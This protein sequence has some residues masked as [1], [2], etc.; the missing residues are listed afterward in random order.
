[1]SQGLC[2]SCGAVANLP[3]EHNQINCTYCGSVVTRQEAEA[4]AEEQKGL[5]CIGSVIL[6]QTS[7]EGGS[8]EEALTHWNDVLKQEPTFSDAWLEKGNCM[9]RTSKIGNIKLTEALSSWKAAI[10]FAKNPEAMKK[11]VA[12]EINNIVID[13]YPV[14][15]SHYQEFYQL[16]DTLREHGNRCLL[17]ESTQSLALEYYPSSRTVAENGITLCDRIMKDLNAVWGAV[18][19]AAMKSIF[20]GAGKSL[21]LG[22][23]VAD[24]SN[25]SAITGELSYSERQR[26]MGELNGKLNAAKSRYQA[27]M[28]KIDPSYSTSPSA[29]GVGSTSA[30]KSTVAHG[31]ASNK[32]PAGICGILLGAFG[33]HKFILGYSKEGL[34]QIVITVVTC[35]MG[36]IIGF[37]EGI[38]YLTKS[39]ADFVK[40]YV[41]G[42]KGWF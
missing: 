14:L 8:Y 31:A 9:V 7:Q 2:P 27:A 39:D 19:S 24:H 25:T 37:I 28:A 10:K 41:E 3:A 17:L 32:I 5:K 18:E 12:L 29:S 42:K 22:G 36:G 34:I 20:T 6:A 40:T 4:K 13:F 15:L 11:R 16:R 21:V 38:I 23:S 30:Q 1:M 26:I 35:G 33:V